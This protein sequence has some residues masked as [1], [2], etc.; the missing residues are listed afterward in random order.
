M[1]QTTWAKDSIGNLKLQGTLAEGLLA[2]RTLLRRH[3]PRYWFLTTY[4]RDR[5][6]I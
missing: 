1:G 4:R 5:Y 6:I 3:F 2:V